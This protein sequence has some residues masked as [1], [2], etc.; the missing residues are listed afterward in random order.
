MSKDEFMNI[1]YLLCNVDEME[2]GIYKDRL[3]ME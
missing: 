3:L 2:S 1:R